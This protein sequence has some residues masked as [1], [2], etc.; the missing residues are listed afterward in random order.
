M[1]A[2]S[3]FYPANRMRRS[4]RAL[5]IT[6]TELKLI[7]AAAIMGSS[8]AD[9]P[10]MGTS[11]PAATNTCRRLLNLATVRD[12]THLTFGSWPHERCPHESPKLPG[13]K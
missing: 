12:S 13:S 9:I 10:K 7:A 5:P 4:L 2:S 11:I 6:E 3:K 1:T 8:S